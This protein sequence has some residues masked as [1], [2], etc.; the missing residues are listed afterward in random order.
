M[1]S[2]EERFYQNHVGLEFP[3]FISVR[4]HLRAFLTATEY[5]AALSPHELYHERFGA[6]L[7]STGPIVVERA[8]YLNADGMVW[9]AGTNA[10]ATRL[11]VAP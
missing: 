9:S 3:V 1:R 7:S 5:A 2:I 11:T 8:L 4:R 10:T 6:V